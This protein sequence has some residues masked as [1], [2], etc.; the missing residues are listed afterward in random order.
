MVFLLDVVLV[1][2]WD[3]DAAVALHAA[4]YS[5]LD[6]VHVPRLLQSRALRSGGVG[7]VSRY[8]KRCAQSI[9]ADLK[10]TKQHHDQHHDQ[11]GVFV[12]DPALSSPDIRAT[13][14]QSISEQLTSM[15]ARSDAQESVK[16]RF[17]FH[18][19]QHPGA[20]RGRTKTKQK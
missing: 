19:I 13:F 4:E 14:A 18:E 8:V 15:C 12:F 10:Q 6:L 20:A 5:D 7:S 11:R 3:A 16:P 2:G 17:V 9:L 1:F